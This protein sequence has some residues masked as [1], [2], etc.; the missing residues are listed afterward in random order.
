MLIET[1]DNVQTLRQ[2]QVQTYLQRG[3]CN[4]CDNPKMGSF[5]QLVQIQR[6]FHSRHSDKISK[7]RQNFITRWDT[8][9]RFETYW[10]VSV[11]AFR[12]RRGIFRHKSVKLSTVLNA[13]VETGWAVSIYRFGHKSS[14]S[15]CNQIKMPNSDKSQFKPVKPSTK[16][17]QYKDCFSLCIPTY[18][19][20]PDANQT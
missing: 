3:N 11:Y 9:L 15:L 5:S 4:L 13:S 12:K 20:I 1:G 2:F 10:T 16:V 19:V 14:F 7:V 6:H 18:K 17:Y 8:N